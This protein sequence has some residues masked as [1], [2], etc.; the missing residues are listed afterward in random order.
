MTSPAGT[1]SPIRRM[2]LALQTLSRIS[3]L[4]RRVCRL[5]LPNHGVDIDRL[6]QLLADSEFH[7]GRET[8]HIEVAD[9]DRQAHLGDEL[10]PDAGKF[11]DKIVAIRLRRFNHEFLRACEYGAEALCRI[12]IGLEPALLG[13]H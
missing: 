2:P 5:A 8:L 12:A 7:V 10:G 9:K 3:R 11:R 4:I 6:H 1:P 13:K